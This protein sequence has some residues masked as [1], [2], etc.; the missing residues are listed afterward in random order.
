MSLELSNLQKFIA[1]LERAI[2]VYEKEGQTHAANTDLML[3]LQAG[4]IQS[5]KLTYDLSWKFIKRWIE[6]NV[7]TVAVDGVTRRE[8]FRQGAENKLIVD[9]E[10]WMDF[11]KS[12]NF[13]SHIYDVEIAREVFASSIEF[14]PYTKQLL[15][16]LEE[17]NT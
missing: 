13:T 1:S 8:L 17:N 2:N 12:R 14:L 4:V 6:D 15:K 11:H 9:V 10:K 3:T 7:S 5:F 16:R